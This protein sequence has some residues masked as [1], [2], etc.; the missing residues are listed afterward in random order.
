MITNGKMKA[1]KLKKIKCG[2]QVN[3]QFVFWLLILSFR[4]KKEREYSLVKLKEQAEEKKAHAERVERRV[5]FNLS[6]KTHCYY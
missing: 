6:L 4:E 1:I 3:D 2:F 5:R